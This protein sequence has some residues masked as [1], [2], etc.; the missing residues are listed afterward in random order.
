MIHLIRYIFFYGN[1]RDKLPKLQRTLA[2]DFDPAELDPE[3]RLVLMTGRARDPSAVKELMKKH[4]V[5]TALELIPYL[6]KRIP[7][8]WQKRFRAWLRGLEGS[9]Q[10]DPLANELKNRD[11]WM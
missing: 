5:Y 10:S 11:D 1:I 8:P 3:I 2:T 7:T 9:Y 6:P 4:E